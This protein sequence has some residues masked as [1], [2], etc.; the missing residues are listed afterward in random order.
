MRQ[1]TLL[2]A[3]QYG[4]VVGQS[5]RDESLNLPYQVLVKFLGEPH[6][7]GPNFPDDNGKVD[8]CWGI[9]DTSGNKILIWN[10]KNGPAYTG[11]G[12]IES[13]EVFS[14]YVTDQ[15]F[16]EELRAALKS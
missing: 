11:H 14:V 9:Q 10:Y 4:E 12:T 1:F 5:S 3:T 8:V 7:H 2:D 13:I 15:E 6:K 16:F